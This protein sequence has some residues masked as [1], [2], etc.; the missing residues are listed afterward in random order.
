MSSWARPGVECI[1]RNSAWRRG[2]TLTIWQWLR[3]KALGLPV[4]GGLYVVAAVGQNLNGDGTIVIRLRGFG[5][6]WFHSACFSPVIKH[7]QEQDLE[8]FWPLLDPN[9]PLVTEESAE[10]A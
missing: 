2:E 3:H 1:C 7:T 8:L 6:L 5:P 10:D 4:Y 9:M